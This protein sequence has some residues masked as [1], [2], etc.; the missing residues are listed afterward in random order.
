[1]AFSVF[2]I[3]GFTTGFLVLLENTLSLIVI[4]DIIWRF[5]LCCIFHCFFFYYYE[6]VCMCIYTYIKTTLSIQYINSPLTSLCKYHLKIVVMIY[7]IY[8]YNKFTD[9]Q[10]TAQLQHSKVV[11]HN[12]LYKSSTNVAQ[13]AVIK[14]TQTKDKMNLLQTFSN[15][16]LAS[17]RACLNGVNDKHQQ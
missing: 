10:R 2:F 17:M 1:M 8:I 11:R 14:N 12:R 5:Y 6:K 13:W 7:I 9:I 15:K 4:L 3:V 16:F